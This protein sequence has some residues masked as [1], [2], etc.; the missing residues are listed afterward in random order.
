MYLLYH[1]T[2]V[3]YTVYCFNVFFEQTS[4]QVVVSMLINLP[5]VRND[6]VTK[7]NRELRI[8][9]GYVYGEIVNRNCVLEIVNQELR[10][11]QS[12]IVYR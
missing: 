11:S 2:T 1:I 9:N 12:R 3:S 8:E 7:Q 6:R 4:N 10:I 5:L